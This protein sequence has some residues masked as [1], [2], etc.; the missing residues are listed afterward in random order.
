MWELIGSDFQVTLMNLPGSFSRYSSRQLRRYS[1]IEA[2]ACDF[3]NIDCTFDIVFSNSVIEHV[4]E[5]ERQK[6]FAAF[7]ISAGQKYWVQ[8]PSPAFPMEAHCNIPFW[9]HLPLAAQD[10]F[11]EKWRLIGNEFLVAQMETTIPIFP[12]A[13]RELFPDC[14]IYTE[15]VLGLPKSNVAYGEQST[16]KR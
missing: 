11:F 12:S 7:I 15:R 4:G 3:P 14:S 16:L 6:C 8:T 1:I 9:W 2:D 13:L 10:Y 5:A